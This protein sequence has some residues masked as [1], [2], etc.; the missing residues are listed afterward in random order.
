MNKFGVSA[1]YAPEVALGIALAS[2]AAS[3]LSIKSELQK[4][5]AELAAQRKAADE[6]KKNETTPA[7][8]S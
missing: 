3:H 4:L 6:K 2:I 8:T 7:Q 5:A 1:E